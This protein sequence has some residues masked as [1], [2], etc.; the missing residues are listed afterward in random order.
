MLGIASKGRGIN[1]ETRGPQTGNDRSELM[2][3][4][5]TASGHW[6]VRELGG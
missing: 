2:E 6:H 4:E 5:E 1:K 3:I